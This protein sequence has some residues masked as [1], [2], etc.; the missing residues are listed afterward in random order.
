[1][2]TRMLALGTVLVIASLALMPGS[3]SSETKTVNA[4]ADGGFQPPNRTV[5]V[6]DTIT[7]HSTDGNPHNVHADDGGFPDVPFGPTDGRHKFT[8]GQVGA[9]PYHC[10]I[11]ETMTGSVTVEPAPTTTTK[12]PTTTTTRP[13]TTSTRASTTSSSSTSSSSSSTSSSTS[14][15]SSSSTTSTTFGGID[16]SAVTVKEKGGGGG[17]GPGTLLALV[18][19]AGGI[20]LIIGGLV[21]TRREYDE[22]DA[23]DPDDVSYDDEGD[24]GDSEYDDNDR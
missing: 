13:T 15:S 3:A 9:H 16:E 22:V 17:G 21:L 6:G 14:S 23:D 2:A 19:L 4:S 24:D 8:A 1:M 20:F 5:K 10:T 7:W 11:H 12:K 18:G